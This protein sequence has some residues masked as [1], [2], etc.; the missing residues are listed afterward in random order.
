VELQLS[1]IGLRLM[2]I[3]MRESP[4]VVSRQ[5]IEREIWGNGLPDSDTLRSH[6]YNLRKIIDKPLLH[7]RRLPHRR[8]R[9]AGFGLIHSRR[10]ARIGRAIIQAARGGDNLRPLPLA[11]TRMPYGLSRKMRLA[12]LLQAGVLV[13]TVLVGVYLSITLINYGLVK[14]TLRKEADYFWSLH[15]TST[16]QPPPNTHTI[17]GYLLPTG[18]SPLSLPENLRGLTPGFHDLKDDD[19]LVLV[20]QREEGRLYLAFQRSQALTLW[21]WFGIVPMLGLLLAMYA[22]I[23]VTYRTSKRLVSPVT[24]WHGRCS[25]G[26]R[27]GPRAA[28]CRPSS[29]RPTCRAMPASWP[30]RCMR[31]PSAPASTWRASAISPAM[32][33]T[34]CVRR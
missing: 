34:N 17:R 23:F 21:L 2:T 24:G 32:P 1:P 9:P 19:Q 10:A 12:F 5:E 29:C 7:K 8:H 20:D 15:A 11:R 31:L 22:V 26:I 13:L 28:C 18:Y 3:L 14:N 6:L 25:S 33:A 16:A 27:A 4:R 30:W